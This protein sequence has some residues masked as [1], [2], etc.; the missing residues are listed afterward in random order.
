MAGNVLVNLTMF[1]LHRAQNLNQEQ[2]KTTYLMIINLVTIKTIITIIP[3]TQISDQIKRKKIIYTNY[4]I[5]TIKL[6]IITL[7]PALPLVY[8]NVAIYNISTNIF[9]TIN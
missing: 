4:A 3:S 2:T 7:A 5:N 1:Y 6:A 8:T 9:L